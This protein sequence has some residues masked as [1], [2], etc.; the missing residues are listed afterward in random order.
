MLPLPLV[1]ATWI[2]GGRRRSGWPSLPSRASRRSRLRSISRGCSPC[3]RATMPSMRAFMRGAY[4]GATPASDIRRGGLLPTRSA[5]GLRFGRRLIGSATRT[6]ARRPDQP[7]RAEPAWSSAPPPSAA[8]MTL[9]PPA[10][11]LYGRSRGH[12]LRPRQQR[13]LD[14]TLPRLIFPAVQASDPVSAFPARPAALWLEVGF[15]GGEHALAQVAA[16][17]EAG[18][19]A[20]EVFENGIC[21]LLSRL[22]PEGGEADASAAAQPAALA[23]RRARA[24]A[25]AAG[26]LPGPAVPAVS[27]SVAEGA[28]RQAPLRASRRCCRWSHGR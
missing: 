22:V 4:H 23:G 17:P 20:C 1:P 13:L 7:A 9:K 27:R 25:C 19:I 5:D 2:T 24:A 26:C 21:S 16:H 18:L 10:E 8:C 12:R 15:G 28:P 14:L 6:P 3:S 11:R